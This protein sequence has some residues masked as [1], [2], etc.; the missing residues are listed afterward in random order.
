M[1]PAACYHCGLPVGEPGRWRAPLLGEAREFCCAG[2]EAVARTIVASGGA[3][4]YETRSAPAAGPPPAAP[5][6]AQTYD[7]P[8]AQ[9]QFVA[10]PGEHERE[11]TLLLERLGCAACAWLSERTLRALP[12]V[13]R[14]DVNFAARRAQVRWDERRIRFSGL[15]EALRA[16]GYDA[17]PYDPRRGADLAREERRAALGRLFVAGFGAMQVMMYAI[18]AYL[19]DGASLAADAAQLMRWASLLLTLPVVLYACQPF[20]AS[21]WRDFRQR[22]ISLDTPI[23]LGIAAAFAASA[24][25]TVVGAGPVYFDSISML[26]F[27]LLGARYIELAARQRAV[28][29]LDRLGRWVPEF[30]LRIGAA[31][32]EKVAAHAL[33]AGDRVLVPAGE[34][35]PADGTVVAGASSADESLLTGESRPIAKRAGSPVT[36]GSINLEQPLT[37]RVTRTGA[38]TSAAAITRLVERA[39]AGK[40][41]LV[42]A[43]D[44]IAR[45][46]TWV[47]LAAALLGW[48]HSGEIG[49]A[50]AVLVAT[51]PC[52]LA[53]ASPIA[54]TTA[55][56]RLLERGAVLARAP[57]LETLAK[58][59]DVVLDKTGTLTAGTFRVARVEATG[60]LDEAACRALAARLES[61]SRHPIAR[62]LAAEGV[63][64]LEGARNAP[65][66]GIEALAGARR[67]RA[68]TA[69]FCAELAGSRFPNPDAAPG[70]TPV[71]L[72]EE[73]RWLAR[74]LLEDA[75]RPEAAAM[76]RDLRGAG[77]RVHLL[78]GDEPKVVEALARRLGVE[79]ARGGATPGDKA[80]FVAA[81]QRQGKFVA[82]LGDGLNDTPVLARA[83]VSV[84]IGGG[85]EAAQSQADLV[86][87]AARLGAFAD[88][89][90]I[91]RGA[92]RAIR[93][94]FFWAL[95]YNAVAL[96]LAA[97]GAVGPLEAALGMAA[98]SFLVV[99]NAARFAGEGRPW[100]A[101]TSSF[102]S[103]SPSYS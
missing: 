50:I 18:P 92:M 64:S 97:L 78:S 103:R 93:Q 4:Y 51:C 15:V 2:C 47:V 29:E 56:A 100:K 89:R 31:G 90:G 27:L 62:A 59:T 72:A 25:A 70:Y 23:A 20:F 48:W 81:L 44:R 30:A 96:P 41:R 61:A 7:D 76:V 26:A 42:L 66:A 58:V 5:I 37:V 79:S 6:P 57:A 53:L 38:D 74:F 101:S 22:R 3:R 95:A 80:E 94:N 102:P 52:A 83:D 34:R 60:P 9:R 39:A 32:A 1:A 46:L 85:A 65:G 45:S 54:L 77:L 43:A 55:S 10:S 87:P 21:A 17:C 24:A 36:G 33:V 35:V 13:L 8:L 11:A 14:A 86:L 19:D 63:D 82:M 75:V 40:P 99:L 49:V 73:G 91:S 98:S 67:M 28:R 12:G 84:A 69:A 16:V 68:G 88:A 71:F